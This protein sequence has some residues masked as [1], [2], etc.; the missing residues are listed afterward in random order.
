MAKVENRLKMI[1]RKIDQSRI[2]I[3]DADD[4]KSLEGVFD[5]STLKTLYFLANKG[6]IDALGGVIS[7]GKE[8]NVFHAL[9]CG[10]ERELAIKIYRISTS[11]FKAMQSYLIGDPRFKDIRHEKRSIVFAWTKKEMRN[12]KKAHSAGVR[13]PK[14]FDTRNNILLMEFIG[15]DE[16][17][18]QQLRVVPLT[19]EEAKDAYETTI[20]YVRRLY[21]AN[22]VHAD[23]SE[24]NI[25][26][27]GREV[28][29][30]DMGQS[31]TLDHPNAMEFLQR[32]VG[33]VARFF[34]KKGVKI[35]SDAALKMV[36]SG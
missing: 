21:Q 17:P 31:V 30:I 9:G 29:F 32:D 2:R 24:F 23:L 11:N 14:P 33:N 3:K 19:P 26:M 6:E 18:A 12:L 13:V 7:T 34:K 5:T 10:S 28:V 22:L 15:E 16:L 36:L 4:L 25:L 1:D 8:A 27:D 35:D 20:E